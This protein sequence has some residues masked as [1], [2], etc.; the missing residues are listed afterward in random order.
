MPVLAHMV[1]NLSSVRPG[2]MAQTSC[3]WRKEATL[4]TRSCSASY[5]NILISLSSRKD[6]VPTSHRFASRFGDATRA[7]DTNLRLYCTPISE[8]IIEAFEPASQKK[9]AEVEQ[10]RP[11]AAA[12]SRTNSIECFKTRRI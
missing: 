5:C 10:W 8:A 9:E 1:M 4:T 11:R 3:A 7:R 6:V 2:T 12:I